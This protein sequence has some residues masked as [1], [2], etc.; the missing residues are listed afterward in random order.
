MT[1]NANIALP[2]HEAWKVI[3]DNWN[4]VISNSTIFKFPLPLNTPGIIRQYLNRALAAGKSCL[5]DS[6]GIDFDDLYPAQATDLQARLIDQ[7]VCLG[8]GLGL[9]NSNP[10][11]KSSWEKSTPPPVTSTTPLIAP[12]T[13]SKP[14]DPKKFDGTRSLF[15][16][17]IT[18][19]QLQFRSNPGAFGSDESK[20]L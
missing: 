15:D 20:I 9:G 16:N 10:T 17:Y 13:A 7:A 11:F 3:R 12:S 19:L 4:S 6:S 2:N 8:Q 14:S 5:G 1:D 18:K